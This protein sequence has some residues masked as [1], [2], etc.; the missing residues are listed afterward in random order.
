MPDET[1]VEPKFELKDFSQE[2]GKKL[3]AEI[4]EILVKY[5]GQFLVTPII[6]TNGTLGATVNVLKK[7]LVSKDVES[8]YNGTPEQTSE[9]N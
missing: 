6:N 4:E 1:K 5:D 2:E 9:T 7:V 8:P 3:L